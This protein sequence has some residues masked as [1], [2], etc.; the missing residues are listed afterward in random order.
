MEKQLQHVLNTLNAISEIHGKTYEWLDKQLSTVGFHQLVS[1]NRNKTY[2]FEDGPNRFE[3]TLEAHKPKDKIS[4]DDSN[5]IKDMF[6]SLKEYLG[7]LQFQD[8]VL[9]NGIQLAEGWSGFF[10]D[11][12]ITVTH[13]NIDYSFSH[14]IDPS[15]QNATKRFQ[16]IFAYHIEGSTHIG[17]TAQKKFLDILKISFDNDINVKLID[18]NGSET[19]LKSGK[20]LQKLK[21]EKGSKLLLTSPYDD[22]VIN[23]T[24]EIAFPYNDYYPAPSDRN[25]LH[26]IHD[27]CSDRWARTTELTAKIG[28]NEDGNIVQKFTD[29]INEHKLSLVDKNETGQQIEL[30]IP[31]ISFSKVFDLRTTNDGYLYIPIEQLDILEK[32]LEKSQ[33]IKDYDKLLEGK[34]KS[35]L[36][37]KNNKNPVLF[38]FDFAA[39]IE[40]FGTNVPAKGQTFQDNNSELNSNEDKIISFGA[41]VG[42]LTKAGFQLGLPAASALMLTGRIQSDFGYHQVAPAHI[43]ESKF[44][45]EHGKKGLEGFLNKSTFVAQGLKINGD[46]EKFF[47]IGNSEWLDVQKK[48][49]ELKDGTH[50]KLNEY[51]S[52]RK[53]GHY[54]EQA[55]KDITSENRQFEGAIVVVTARK[56]TYDAI[57][58][59]PNA[60]PNYITMAVTPTQLFSALSKISISDGT[61]KK[62]ALADSGFRTTIESEH[63]VKAV[64]R[65]GTNI[66]NYGAAHSGGDARDTYR[67]FEGNDAQLQKLDKILGYAF[68]AISAHHNA[69]IA[70][71]IRNDNTIRLL[72]EVS[73][74][75]VTNLAEKQNFKS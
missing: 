47:V 20:D 64:L 56:P 6:H 17:H 27:K 26:D 48:V 52:Q 32:A 13:K 40:L 3:L 18:A 75:G 49:T 4:F 11:G 22:K 66:Y 43:L 14:Y 70:D 71:D 44:F 9:P 8:K 57:N 10:H 51:I 28:I 46:H 16:D 24:I 31:N 73:Q 34:E 54:E 41:S 61:S 59:N 25:I 21:F 30:Q 53:N 2:L 7:E 45:S 35:P 23:G 74:P 12:Q 36:L 29:K 63:M 69:T 50:D 38:L 15:E 1:K 42:A 58:K 37:S 65:A 68:K 62:N 67:V 39:C 19:D 5:T 55:I 72:K 33:K 60:D